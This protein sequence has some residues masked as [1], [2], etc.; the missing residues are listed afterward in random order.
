MP[1]S[2]AALL[3]VDF[4]QRI[5][6]FAIGH[7]MTGTARPLGPVNHKNVG[8]LLEQVEKLLAEWA[9]AVVVIG[10]PLAMDGSETDMSRRARDFAR[11]I[12]GLAPDVAVYLHDERLTSDAAA[13]R[14]AQRRQ[15]GRGSRRDG[16]RLDSLAA[17]LILE[18]WMASHPADAQ[19]PAGGKH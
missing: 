4:G 14:H 11:R 3:G 6:G 13:Q 7:R 15:Q 1:D 8:T 17:G 19:I 5:T 10:L 12:R 9:P 2:R 18:S 16:Q